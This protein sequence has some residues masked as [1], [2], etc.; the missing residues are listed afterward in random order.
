MS[1]FKIIIEN[2]KNEY[3]LTER[4]KKILEL[5]IDGKES[6]DMKNELNIKSSTLKTHFRNI[7]R[8]TNTRNQKELILFFMHKIKIC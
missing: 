3:F 4:E 5:L 2:F 1:K 8:K 6:V 7:Y